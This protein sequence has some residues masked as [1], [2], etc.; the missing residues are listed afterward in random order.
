MEKSVHTQDTG[1]HADVVAFCPWARAL[2]LLVCATYELRDG[3][4]VGKLL[5]Y[6]VRRSKA[7]ALPSLRSEAEFACAGIF[8]AAWR[9]PSAGDEEGCLL[10]LACADGTVQVVRASREGAD[11]PARLDAVASCELPAAA[12]DA[13]SFCLAADWAWVRDTAASGPV[14]KGAT[15]NLACCDNAGRAHLVALDG[16]LPR[17]ITSWKAH[18]LEI[19][20]ASHQRIAGGLLMTG[21]DDCK[22]KGWDTRD[23]KRPVFVNK[24]HSMGITSIQTDPRAEHVVLTGSYDEHLRIFD[25]RMPQREIASIGLGGGTWCARWHPFVPGAIVAACMHN[26]FQLA[27]ASSDHSKLEHL[28]PCSAPDVG[29]SLGYG[30][31]WSHEHAADPGVPLLGATCSFYNHTLHLWTVEQTVFEARVDAP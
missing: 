30:A 15:S 10:A 20:T 26:G 28:G 2:D 9:P 19:W 12:D 21:A 7:A 29:E 22:L 5:L 11:S 18:D 6:S 31:D 24:S 4:R 17:V 8:D 16:A 25:L 1:L 3:V 14:A 27:R 23:P 13:R